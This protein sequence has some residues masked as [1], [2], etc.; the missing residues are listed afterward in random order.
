MPNSTAKDFA[1]SCNCG[2]LRGA[3]TAAGAKS[4][5][6]TV[7]F[8]HDCRAAQLYFGQPDPAPGPVEV[9]QMLPEEIRI[10]GGAEHLALMQLSPK[11]MLRWYASCCNAPLAV[12]TRTPKFPFAGFIVKRIADPSG[13]GPITTRGFVPQPDGKQS[14]EKL[15]PAVKGLISRVLKSRISGSWKNSVFFDPNTRQPVATPVILS[16]SERAAFYK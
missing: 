15:G 3:I 7:C 12:T 8:C 10:D 16:Q 2:A 1:F 14:H 13:L 5:T 4:A 11:G 6:H 9:L